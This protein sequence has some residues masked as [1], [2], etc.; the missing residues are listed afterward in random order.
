[1]HF[2]NKKNSIV[3]GLSLSFINVQML[4]WS[5]WMAESA[6]NLVTDWS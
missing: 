2:F 1:M 5:V 3:W 6:N 4:R